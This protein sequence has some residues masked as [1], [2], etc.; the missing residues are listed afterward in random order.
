[1]RLWSQSIR[2][3]EW[4]PARYAL[5]RPNPQTH[6][7]LSDN[8]SPH[9]AWEDVPRGTRSYAVLMIDVDVPSRGDD[10][11]QEGRVVPVNLPRVDFYHWVLV[12]LA[13]DLRTLAEGAFSR[14]VVARGKSGPRGALDTRTGLN[15]Y[16]GWFRG[17]PNMQGNYFGYD[18]PCPPWN[19]GRVHHYHLRL[20]ALDV[21]RCPVEGIFTG[22]QMQ[23]A[24]RGRV[25]GEAALTGKYTIYADAVEAP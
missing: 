7:E 6:V 13:P 24:I 20:I 17:D 16:T 8:L 9:L 3:G 11:N 25:L 4:I 19:D 5:G 22:G 1:M 21:A 12:D 23:A 15:D 18:G 2:N 10:V 14:G